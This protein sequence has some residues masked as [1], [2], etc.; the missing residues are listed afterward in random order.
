MAFMI[1]LSSASLFPHCILLLIVPLNKKFFC[2]TIATLSLSGCKPYS[3]T[4]WP[5]TITSP[6]V[7]S[8]NL[9]IKLTNVDL[10]EPVE[11]II[12]T[13]SPDLILM[14]K[15]VTEYLSAS[16]L[17]LKETLL[18]ITEPSLTVSIGFS[19]STIV[20][21][22]SRTSPIRLIDSNY[23]TNIVIIIEIIMMDINI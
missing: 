9:E 16:L 14:F 17:Y 11:P 22:S 1:S 15:L 18:K 12:P 20:G 21:S 6:S 5:P 13:N 4:L 2:K 19:G 7:V 23:M 10:P 3:L 8:Y